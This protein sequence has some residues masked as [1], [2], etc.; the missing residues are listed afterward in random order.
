MIGRKRGRFE[1]FLRVSDVSDKSDKSDRSDRTERAGWP[2]SRSEVSGPL[3]ANSPQCSD[4]RLPLAV[5]EK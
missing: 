4:C 2:A 3:A 5:E 1:G